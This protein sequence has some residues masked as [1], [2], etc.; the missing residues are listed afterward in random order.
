LTQARREG[1]AA[2]VNLFLRHAQS[3]I[4]VLESADT[5]PERHTIEALVAPFADPDVGMT[6]GRPVPVNDRRTFMGVA[7][8]LLWDMHHEVAARQPKMGEL[9]AFRRVFRRIPHDSAVDEA[10]VEPLIH[11]QGFQLRY[12][13]EAILYT[14][15]PQTAADFIK[16]RRRIHAGHL[17]MRQQQGY[18]VS[19]MRRNNLAHALLA[20]WRWTWRYLAWTPG[21]VALEAYARWLGA[22]DYWRGAAR[23]HA[24]WDI[25]TSTK[26]ALR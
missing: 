12:V 20:N 17:H 10:S 4:V 13:P 18:V 6:G 14:R 15:G 3:G 19:T 7:V 9:I 2:A 26:G 5:L 16:Q 11:G 21:V 25:A 8:H 23:R 24:V 1:K 22:L